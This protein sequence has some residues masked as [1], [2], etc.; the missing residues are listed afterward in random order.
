[1]RVPKYL[2]VWKKNPRFWEPQL[3]NII[4]DA[5]IEGGV[6]PIREVPIEF[7]ATYRDT[8]S[9][10]A[11]ACHR[12]GYGPA[13]SGKKRW[14]NSTF[15][16]RDEQQKLYDQNMISPGVP[17]PGHAL[18]AVPGTSPHERGIGIDVPDVRLETKLIRECRKLGLMDDVP[19]EKWHLTN[20][21]A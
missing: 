18:T 5:Y 16:F 2:R 7:R 4:I 9:R 15:R 17:K 11:L 8:L 13:K 1:M 10:F 20:H 19:S 21:R 12:A 6:V 3:D 14:V